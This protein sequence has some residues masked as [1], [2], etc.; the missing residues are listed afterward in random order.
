MTRTR[1]WFWMKEAQQAHEK[2]LDVSQH[3][4]SSE[5]NVTFDDLYVFKTIM[6]HGM[7]YFEVP[8]S[9]CYHWYY[10]CF[11]VLLSVYYICC[12]YFCLYL[13]QCY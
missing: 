9:Y 2:A 7:H 12:Y 11:F 5:A 13:C 10:H 3:V 6:C 1:L 4:G 8:S